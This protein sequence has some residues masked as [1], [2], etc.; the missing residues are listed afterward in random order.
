MVVASNT[1]GSCLDILDYNQETSRRMNIENLDK[2]LQEMKQL[3]LMKDEDYGGATGEFGTLGIM[4]HLWD[5]INR[6]KTIEMKAI[7]HPNA[8]INFES[9]KDTLMDIMGYSILGLLEVQRRE[10]IRKPGE[11]HG[12]NSTPCNTIEN[13]WTEPLVDGVGEKCWSTPIS[14]TGKTRDRVGRPIKGYENEE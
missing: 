12:N 14:G 4:I 10:E 2:I 9:E 3:L 7:E 5:K 11:W 13:R 6:L 8:K 1:A